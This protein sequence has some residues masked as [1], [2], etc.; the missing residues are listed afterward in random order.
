MEKYII[1]EDYYAD[2]ADILG[3]DFPVGT[4]CT[5]DEDGTLHHVDE[6]KGMHTDSGDPVN[7]PPQRPPIIP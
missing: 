7:P 1:T 5:Q 2:F 3:D 4:I 6:E